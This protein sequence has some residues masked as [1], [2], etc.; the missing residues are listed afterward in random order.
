MTE[1]LKAL[2][3]LNKDNKSLGRVCVFSPFPM[4]PDNAGNRVRLKILCQ[5][6]KDAG[7]EIHFVYHTREDGGNYKAEDLTRH[8]EICDQVFIVPYLG[9]YPRPRGKTYVESDIWDA[10][11]ECFA[12]NLF[13]NIHYDIVIVNY[14]PFARFLTY[15]PF[16]C[17]KIIDTHDKLSGRMSLLEQDGIEPNFYYMDD[18]EEGRLL[19]FADLIISIKEEES[20]HYHK[21]SGGVPVLTLGM[22]PESS[23]NGRKA[24]RKELNPEKIV[25]GFIG[26]TNVVNSKAIRAVAHALAALKDSCHSLDSIFSLN[27]YGAICNEL[28]DLELPACI[29]LKGFIDDAL[30]FYDEVDVVLIPTVRSTGLKIKAIEALKSQ[31]IILA[32]DDGFGGIK[33]KFD[34]HTYDS[35]FSLVQNFLQIL[36]QHT[37]DRLISLN[38]LNSA[39]SQVFNDYRNYYNENLRKFIKSIRRKNVQLKIDWLADTKGWIKTLVILRAALPELS[40]QYELFLSSPEESSVSLRRVKQIEDLSKALTNS[41]ISFLSAKKINLVDAYFTIEVHPYGVLN[42]FKC[43]AASQKMDQYVVS[44]TLLTGFAI[45]SS[46]SSKSWIPR[47]GFTHTYWGK[48]RAILVLLDGMSQETGG[49]IIEQANTYL[50]RQGIKCNI[51]FIVSETA[52]P[53]Y[54]AAGQQV[55]SMCDFLSKP[56]SNTFLGIIDFGEGLTLNDRSFTIYSLSRS[57]YVVNSLHKQEQIQAIRGDGAA[58]S[59][60]YSEG[61][62]F[63]TALEYVLCEESFQKLN[64]SHYS[65]PLSE[66]P[67][68]TLKEFTYANDFK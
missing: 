6:L 55:I 60:A 58:V 22:N 66:S 30:D 31:R 67:L 45:Q 38:L 17:K 48:N 26:S 53:F 3:P 7:F 59:L 41:A 18:C 61:N 16:S 29:K 14:T 9:S 5:D 47:C 43:G 4:F 19:A 20:A 63:V 62:A 10:S 32:T 21:I 25:A 23:W 57:F 36:N 52:V 28:Q 54:S 33:S 51:E 11:I 42:I 2:A 44:Q 8:K 49:P 68:K 56:R 13:K 39:T 24:L 35:V 12:Q 1:A 37:E 34:F 50:S 27:V 15:A 64:T 65:I 46:G 40:L